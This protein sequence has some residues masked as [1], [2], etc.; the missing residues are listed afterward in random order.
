MDVNSYAY[1]F[2]EPDPTI[3][4]SRVEEIPAKEPKFHAMPL[5]SALKKKGPGSG[6]G[7]PTQENRPLTLR[8]E[9]HASFK[10]D[11]F[12]VFFV[13]N[14]ESLFII[15]FTLFLTSFLENTV[16]DALQSISNNIYHNTFCLSHSQL[17]IH[18]ATINTYNTQIWS[19]FGEN[20]I[21]NNIII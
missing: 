6:P 5:K 10:Y 3:D 7:T 1:K 19:N 20:L 8:Q 14:I 4:T 9:L 15:N 11:E 2:Y 16:C 18:L 13:I 12:F 21:S 17:A